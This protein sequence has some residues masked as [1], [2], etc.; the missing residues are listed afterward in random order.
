MHYVYILK[1]NDGSYYTGWT[2]DLQN[3]ITT[4]NSGKGAKYTRGRTPVTLVYHEVFH[5]KGEALRREASI[6][7]LSRPAK[8]DLIKA[9]SVNI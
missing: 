7:K 5:D 6:K 2:T 1:C 4:H 3:R 8:E 9:S